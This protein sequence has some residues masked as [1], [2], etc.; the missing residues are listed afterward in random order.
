MAKFKGFSTIDKVKAPYTVTDS[1]LI[2]R[3]L[4]NELYTRKGERVMRPEFGSIVWDI[5]MNPSTASLDEEI[6]EDI[7]RIIEK[8]PRVK[9]LNVQVLALDHS[10]RAEVD[11]EILPAGDPEKLYIEYKKDIVEGAN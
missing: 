11:I 6:R 9:L 5:L 10:V 4:L 3:D 7:S 8:D 2:K 1:E